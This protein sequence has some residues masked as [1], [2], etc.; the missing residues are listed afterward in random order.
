MNFVTAGSMDSEISADES[1]FSRVDFKG[2]YDCYPM[3]IGPD[4]FACSGEFTAYPLTDP[5]LGVLSLS[6]KSSASALLLVNSCIASHS[7][8]FSSAYLLV[9]LS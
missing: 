7:Y 8:S 2:T 5:L 6:V 3:V 4:S 1:G 9:S